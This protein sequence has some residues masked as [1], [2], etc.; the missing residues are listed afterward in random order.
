M[1]FPIGCCGLLW[2]FQR[3]MNRKRIRRGIRPSRLGRV[4]C[5]VMCVARRDDVFSC[6]SVNSLSRNRDGR[7]MLRRTTRCDPSFGV[8]TGDFG[9]RQR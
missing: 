6:V 7:I 4:P 9:A 2:L 8:N 3:L 1:W 5:R